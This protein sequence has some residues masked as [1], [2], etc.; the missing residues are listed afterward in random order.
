MT[1]LQRPDFFSFFEY[2]DD[3]YFFIGD[4][5]LA[6]IPTRYEAH[7]LLSYGDTIRTLC[8]FDVE[9]NKQYKYGYNFPAVVTMEPSYIYKER[10]DDVDF[11]VGEFH[12]GDK[13]IA[14][15]VVMQQPFIAYA[16]FVE[17]I[18]NGRVPSFLS[19]NQMAVL[20]DNISRICNFNPRINHAVFEMIYAH[21]S[22]DPDNMNIKY[23]HTDMKKPAAHIGLRNVAYGTDST[24]TR[25][26]GAYAGDGINAVLLNKS[27]ENHDMEDLLRL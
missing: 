1:G 12:K 15:D 24:T 18:N 6:K 7:N 14:H 10:E 27:L 4:T 13:F 2:K 9:I 25:L 16:T 3:A 26:I 19:Y 11:I 22:R 17:F 23:R 21:L 5:L 8:I 20:F